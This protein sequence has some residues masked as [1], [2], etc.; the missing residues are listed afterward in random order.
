M[1]RKPSS[2]NCL[3]NEES[4]T[5]GTDRIGTERTGPIH[6]E[7]IRKNVL[8]EIHVSSLEVNMKCLIVSR[9]RQIEIGA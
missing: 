9:F 2:T 8:A 4:I 3:E 7:T 6:L 5:S 1:A